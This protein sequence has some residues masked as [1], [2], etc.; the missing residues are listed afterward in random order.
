[1]D[2]VTVAQAL[3]LSRCTCALA[4]S[5]VMSEEHPQEQ[6]GA[7]ARA[8]AGVA[9]HEHA[10]DL[11]RFLKPAQDVHGDDVKCM[12][13]DCYI[14]ISYAARRLGNIEAAVAQAQM[15]VD[16]A[17]DIRC[18]VLGA[19]AHAALAMALFHTDRHDS[20]SALVLHASCACAI[21]KAL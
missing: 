2:L 8:L 6:P 17:A 9:V 7:F 3:T 15:A 5:N 1:V 21:A 12:V 18:S 11:Q 20:R 4:D 19:A 10:P 16:T 14:G 13:G